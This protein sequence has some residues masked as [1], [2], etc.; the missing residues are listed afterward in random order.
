M[1]ETVRYM[2]DLHVEIPMGTAPEVKSEIFSA[3]KH[4]LSSAHYA[5]YYTVAP[6]VQNF[7]FIVSAV[8]P[9]AAMGGLRLAARMVIASDY[10]FEVF[11]RDY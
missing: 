9:A 10:P 8:D 1:D 11:V 5:D 2:V 6:G 3:L 4:L 7:R